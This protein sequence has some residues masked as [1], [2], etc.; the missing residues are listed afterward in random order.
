M[1]NLSEGIQE[2]DCRRNLLPRGSASLNRGVGNI[3]AV[4]NVLR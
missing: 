1:D 4:R 2:H 3:V